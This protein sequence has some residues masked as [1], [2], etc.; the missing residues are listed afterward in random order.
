[1]WCSSVYRPHSPILIKSII[2]PSLCLVQVNANIS[3]GIFYFFVRVSFSHFINLE[4]EMAVC[5]SLVTREGYVLFFKDIYHGFLLSSPALS[6]Y[7]S[8]VVVKLIVNYSLH[9]KWGSD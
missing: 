3:A 2:S 7:T 6:C 1:M 5:P 8:T 4:S 9:R